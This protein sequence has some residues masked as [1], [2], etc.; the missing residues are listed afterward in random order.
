[1]FEPQ[2][3]SAGIYDGGV[4][5]KGRSVSRSRATSMFE[6]ELPLAEGGISYVD[7]ESMPVSPDTLICARAG[8]VR[9]T[10]FPFRCYYLHMI[11]PKESTLYTALSALPVFVHTAH[12]EQYRAIFERLT[13]AYSRS[14]VR[15]R[16]SLYSAVFELAHCLVGDANRQLSFQGGR[17][18]GEVV[19]SA[20]QYIG[21]SLNEDLSLSAMAT[22]F[23][24]S[25]VHFHRLFKEGTGVTLRAFVEGERIRRATDL[26]VSTDMT[27]TEIAYAVGFSSQSYFSAAFRRR[28]GMTPRAYEQAE[29][30]RY[31]KEK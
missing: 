1:M 17:G 11:V 3:V 20:V 9:H 21:E 16:L 6:L 14:G 4:A 5:Q 26:I 2:I 28:T 18:R 7:G 8:Q 24:F 22:R 15:D 29:F 23:G 25:P 27:L 13:E 19:R 12:P 10:R 30:A 31:E